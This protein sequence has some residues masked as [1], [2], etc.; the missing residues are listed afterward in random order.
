MRII[1]FFPYF[2]AKQ[3]RW[4]YYPEPE[5]PTI[6]EPF[7]GSAAYATHYPDR[8]VILVEKDE[9][10]AAIWDW[11]IHVPEEEFLRV[12]TFDGVERVSELGIT[13][14]GPLNFLRMWA[15]DPSCGED[16][17]SNL[18]RRNIERNPNSK[19][20][21]LC[22]ERLSAQLRLIRHWEVWHGSWE[23]VDV[24]GFGNLEATWFVDPPYQEAGKRYK[25]GNR[26]IDFGRLGEWCQRRRGQAIVC[27]AAGADWLPFRLLRGD[28]RAKNSARDGNLGRGSKEVIWTGGVK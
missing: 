26:G 18:M 6:I 2:G 4:K 22:R 14:P 16:K 25:H 7:A 12:P 19:W 5:Y 28:G 3:S 11:L 24:D 9:R 10:V 21:S 1:R 13:D 27:E 15:N 8:K 17:I 20:S 23:D